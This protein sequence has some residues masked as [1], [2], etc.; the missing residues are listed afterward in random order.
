MNYFTTTIEGS[1]DLPLTTITPAPTGV[2]IAAKKSDREPDGGLSTSAP[3]VVTNTL[4]IPLSNYTREG[5]T[6]HI[7]AYVMDSS[8]TKDFQITPWLTFGQN[9]NT[10][11]VGLNKQ[12]VADAYFQGLS[13]LLQAD[14]TYSQKQ[15]HR[16]AVYSRIASTNAAKHPIQGPSYETCVIATPQT[17]NKDLIELRAGPKG[18]YGTMPTTVTTSYTQT[19]LNAGLMELQTEGITNQ[20]PVQAMALR[21]RTPEDGKIWNFSGDDGTTLIDYARERERD[22]DQATYSGLFAEKDMRNYK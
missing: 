18:T 3:E 17:E 5:V 21:L 4:L 14:T 10:I 19:A 2:N 16:T 6:D 15:L 7:L 13:H 1:T 8:S 12:E 22:L 20:N 11:R 9:Q